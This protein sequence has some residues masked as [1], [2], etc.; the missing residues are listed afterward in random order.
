VSHPSLGLAPP[1]L[2]A[3]YPVAADRLRQNRE[4]L[5]GQ[6]LAIAVDRD[7][8]L[9]DRHDELALRR[10][11]RDAGVLVDR[12]AL[13][14]A[15]N[16]PHWTREWADWIAPILRRRKVPMDDLVSVAEGLRRAAYAVLTPAERLPADAALDEA[17]KVFRWYRRLAGDARKR[18]RILAAIYKGA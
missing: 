16:D 9:G 4:R 18:N 3:G 14:V 6:A 1:D 13:S 15:G 17:V 11:L 7:P 12:V 2:T 8:T 10:L 5:A